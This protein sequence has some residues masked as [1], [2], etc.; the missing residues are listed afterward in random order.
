MVFQAAPVNCIWELVDKPSL[1]RWHTRLT[2][3]SGRVFLQAILERSGGGQRQAETIYIFGVT[4]V[5][6]A[7]NIYTGDHLWCVFDAIFGRNLL[8][9]QFSISSLG[10]QQWSKLFMPLLS[11]YLL[12]THSINLFELVDV[13]AIWNEIEPVVWICMLIKNCC[14][15]RI[16]ITWR[17]V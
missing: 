10:C 16:P 7:D 13:A 5:F 1:A 15:I 6:W 4:W 17:L 14:N 11:F 9:N 2:R 8:S 3:L 12:R